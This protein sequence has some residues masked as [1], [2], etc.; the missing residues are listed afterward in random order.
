MISPL[1]PGRQNIYGECCRWLGFYIFG[2]GYGAVWSGI[3][4]FGKVHNQKHLNTEEKWK[5]NIGVSLD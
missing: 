5:E 3:V 4:W 2:V 1:F